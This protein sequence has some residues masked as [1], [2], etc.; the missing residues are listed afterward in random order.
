MFLFNICLTAAVIVLLIWGIFPS[1]FPFM[2]GTGIALFANYGSTAAMHKKII[3]RHARHALLMCSTMLGAA[4]LM[5]ILTSSIGADGKALSP[6]TVEL[7]P[8]AVPSVV[9]CIAAQISLILPPALGR[10]LPLVIGLA[11]VPIGIFFDTDSYFCGLLPIMIGI[12]QAFGAEPM[13]IAAAMVL[14]R[15]AGGFIS[16]MEPAVLL[17]T[18]LAEV[19]IKDHIRTCF[20]YVWAFSFLCILFA[21]VMGKTTF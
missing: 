1:Y 11:A 12:G 14:C 20:P 13:S 7:P 16:L 2:L 4:V 3:K 9:R 18:G 19:D 21:V 5:G 8:D 15:A 6:G 17:G 10:H